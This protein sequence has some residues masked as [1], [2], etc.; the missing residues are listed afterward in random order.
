VNT[1]RET[2]DP[3]PARVQAPAPAPAHAHAPAP[4][5]AQAQA[6]VHVP[7]TGRQEGTRT[8]PNATLSGAAGFRRMEEPFAERMAASPDAVAVVD[9]DR[10]VTYREL[11][12]AAGQVAADLTGS[13]VAPGGLVGLKVGRGWR[14]VAGI[15]GIWRHGSGYVPVDPR[16]PRAR[17]DYI[18]GDVGLRHLVVEAPAGGLRVESHDAAPREG[19]GA[20]GTAGTAPPPVPEDTAYII[21]TSGSTGDP[22]GVV[23]R[24]GHI[25]ALLAACAETYEVGP[26]DVWSL[27][28]SHSF[29]FSVW[30][31]WGALLSGG[32]V[33]VVPH[34]ATTD[35][36]AFAAFL[37]DHRVTVLS[38][39][40]SV[41]GYLVRALTDTPVPLPALRYVVFGG[42]PINPR[43]LLRWYRLGVAPAAEL[44][45]MYGIT[46]ITVHATVARLSP[47]LLRAP[48]GGTLIGAPLPHLSMVLL[49]DGR[50]VPPGVPGEI[51]IAGGGVAEGYLGRPGLTA[52]RFVRL[53]ALG[54]DR[55]WYRTGDYATRRPDGGYEYL[56]RRDD[57][58]KI[59]GFRIELGEIE[60]VL[61]DQP[62]VREC[63]V[64]VADSPGGERLLVGCYV[65]DE[66]ADA[67]SGA[68]TDADTEPGP[69]AGAETAAVLGERLAKLLPRHL[70][71]GRLVRVG[72][73]PLTFSGKLDRTALARQVTT[74]GFGHG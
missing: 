44:Y 26:G 41:F 65:P 8:M 43:T 30:E 53:P 58:V 6:H 20:A 37:A 29:D 46:E 64:V 59:R 16:Y 10:S 55:I 60:A 15:L 13:G 48:S 19:A 61:A 25:L 33:A 39:V 28:H 27:F 22:K 71:P 63:A 68:G 9:A 49:E 1:A 54:D 17:H 45:N 35:P 12:D 31:I 5:Q 51:H 56:G 67:A 32:T 72:A 66:P 70:V 7:P 57:Q 40:P 62:E 69:G 18:V 52:E 34:E 42:E 36:G 4:V 14:V 38:Q 50:P 2:G 24:H 74:E 21:H 23:I 11:W 73:L 3:P 47:A